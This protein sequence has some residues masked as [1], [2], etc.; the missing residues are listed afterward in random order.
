MA[1]APNPPSPRACPVVSP[2]PLQ[3]TTTLCP[4]KTLDRCRRCGG[5]AF[6]RYLPGDRTWQIACGHRGCPETGPADSLPWRAGIRWNRQQRAL[7]ATDKE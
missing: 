2:V 5:L 1:T 6:P 4:W 7:T 3:S